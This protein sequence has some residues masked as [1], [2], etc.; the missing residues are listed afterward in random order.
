MAYL[1]ND[2]LQNNVRIFDQEK[3][4][5]N[6]DMEYDSSSMNKDVE[7]NMNQLV[8]AAKASLSKRKPIYDFKTKN[9]S[10]IN[11]YNDLYHL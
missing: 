7:E 2:N 1:L 9:K 10:F 8:V 6:I 4:N 3:S 5:I 11:L